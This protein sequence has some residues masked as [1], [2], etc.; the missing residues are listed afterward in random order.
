[1]IRIAKWLMMI[2]ASTSA[3]AN[4]TETTFVGFQAYEVFS[5]KAENGSEIKIGEGQLTPRP[6]PVAKGDW[7][8][9]GKSLGMKGDLK[10]CKWSGSMSS[11]EI[12]QYVIFTGKIETLIDRVN[13]EGS[14]LS[15]EDKRLVISIPVCKEFAELISELGEALGLTSDSLLS[16][17]PL[18]ED[19]FSGTMVS[20]ISFANEGHGWLIVNNRLSTGQTAIA[21]LGVKYRDFLTLLSSRQKD[22]EFKYTKQPVALRF[23]QGKV[24]RKEIK[25][26]ESRRTCSKT[27][28]VQECT[29]DPETKK[30]KCVQVPYDV[31]GSQTER[32]DTI[33]ETFTNQIQYMT[34]DLSKVLGVAHLATKTS[35]E[36][37]DRGYCEV[38]EPT[39]RPI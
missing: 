9:I 36:Y 32:T 37:T 8:A 16:A 12:L 7:Q 31:E 15:P 27:V 11:E 18:E 30:G 19:A 13:R 24:N 29:Y 4:K 23:K 1:M 6:T 5:L 33:E 35:S 22:I 20:G 26:Y 28:Y 2:S 14:I 38:K 10:Y 34:P 17:E 3:W 21:H 39:P 25:G